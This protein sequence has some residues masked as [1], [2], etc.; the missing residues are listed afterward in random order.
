MNQIFTAEIDTHSKT[1]FKRDNLYWNFR[2]RNGSYKSR[3]A[4]VNP[5]LMTAKYGGDR[6]RVYGNATNPT[7]KQLNV[8]KGIFKGWKQKERE[9]QRLLKN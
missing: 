8:A 9:R 4:G 2:Y 3:K 6:L 5:I 7:L 1:Q